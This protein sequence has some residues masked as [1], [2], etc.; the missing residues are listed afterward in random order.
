[1]NKNIAPRRRIMKR[2]ESI[3]DQWNR[4]CGD[5]GEM[6]VA[7]RMEAELM[8]AIEDELEKARREGVQD[9]R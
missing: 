3:I 7:I 1:M 8:V 2:V 9:V 4:S 5:N 6:Q